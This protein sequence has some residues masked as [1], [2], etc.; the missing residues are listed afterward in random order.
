MKPDKK[1]GP[2]FF[3]V[4]FLLC[5]FICL[6]AQPLGLFPGMPSG[7]LCLLLACP[8]ALPLPSQ[9]SYCL[10]LDVLASLHFHT[11]SEG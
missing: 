6:S 9:P 8:S 5:V 11:T 10:S 4:L 1:A 3:G 2:L 7:L